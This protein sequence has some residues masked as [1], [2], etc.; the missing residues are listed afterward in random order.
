MHASIDSEMMLD[1]GRSTCSVQVTGRFAVRHWTGVFSWRSR[2]LSSLTQA[3][4]L[5]ISTR[6][7]TLICV[8]DDHIYFDRKRSILLVL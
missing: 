1:N 4:R 7:I 5:D 8:I 6:T 2:R 3:R